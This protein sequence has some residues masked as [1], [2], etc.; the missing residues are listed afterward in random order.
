[1]IHI[2]FI[3]SEDVS[4]DIE[5]KTTSRDKQSR[6]K[7]EVSKSLAPYEPSD[8]LF[9]CVTLYTD[10]HKMNLKDEDCLAHYYDLA[11]GVINDVLIAAH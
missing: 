11:A 7:N 4:P 10:V 1:M 3:N 6:N 9:L 5:H 8:V 2:D